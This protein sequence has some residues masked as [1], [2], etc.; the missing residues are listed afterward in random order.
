MIAL[1]PGAMT[2]LRREQHLV[3]YVD[4]DEARLGLTEAVTAYLP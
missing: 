3:T 4:M 2:G 1:L